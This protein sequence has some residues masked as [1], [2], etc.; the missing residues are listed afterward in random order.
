M[1]V[2]TPGLYVAKVTA[3]RWAVFAGRSPITQH[4]TEA[5]ARAALAANPSFYAYWAGSVSVSVEND[6]RPHTILGA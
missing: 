5:G 2:T 1:T 6:P 3:R 4:V